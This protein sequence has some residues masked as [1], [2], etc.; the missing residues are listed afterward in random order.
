MTLITFGATI[1]F[2]YESQSLWYKFGIDKTLLRT[3][4][5]IGN[6]TAIFLLLQLVPTVRLPFLVATLGVK[7]LLFLHKITG[8]LLFL[9]GLTH[10]T[11]ILLPEGLGNLPIGKKYWPEMVGMSLLFV[12]F[13]QVFFGLFR[14]HLGLSYRRWRIPHKLIGYFSLALLWFHVPFVS[15][16]FQHTVPLTAF[17]VITVILVSVIGFIK[18]RP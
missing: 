5:I 16:S 11:L 10:A 8:V 7:K 1:P 12:F 14:Q 6:T 2:Y 13:L 3:G 17:I 9:F 4:K 15:E 18:L